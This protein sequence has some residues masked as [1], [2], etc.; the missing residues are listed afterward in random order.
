VASTFGLVL[1]WW[2]ENGDALAPRDVDAQF[3]S[4]VSPTLDAVG[5]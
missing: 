3:R 5:A 4:L 2:L 1:T